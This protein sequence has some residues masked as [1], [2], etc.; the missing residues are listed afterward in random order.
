M[1]N[2]SDFVIENG[3]LKKY[4]G[5]GG[6]VIVPEGVTCIGN[7]AFVLCRVL[8]NITLPESVTSIGYSAF[9]GCSA[10]TSITIPEG[11]ISIGYEAFRGC[12][13]LKSITIPESV[14]NV[15]NSSF[16]FC[17]A[18]TGITIPEGV[19]SIGDDAFKN[20]SSLKSVIIPNS[21]TSIGYSAF[22]GCSALKSITLSNGVTSIGGYA[23]AQ[24][25]ALT[26]IF[27][28][29]SV[30]SIGWDAF[31][32][33]SSLR[34]ITIPEGVTS[35]GWD[36]FSGCSALKSITLP[37]SVT[38][39]GD[40]A[41]EGCNKLEKLTVSKKL[42]SL[43]KDPFGS[44]LPKGLVGE[45][46]SFLHALTDGSI[47][48]YIL[49]GRAKTKVWA[50]LPE[51]VK[52]DIFLSRQGKSLTAAYLDC[53][54]EDGVAPLGEALLDKL[55][56]ELS[57]KECNALLSYMT[58]FSAKAPDELLNRLFR[59]L[60]AQKN[61]KKAVEA[62]ESNAELTTLIQQAQAGSSDSES[63]SD[64]FAAMM[65]ANKASAKETEVRL[66]EYY[67][68]NPD[69]LPAIAASDAGTVP[70]AFVAWLITLHEEQR[71]PDWGGMPIVASA[72]PPGLRPEAAEALAMIDARS[73]QSGLLNLAD[74]FLDKY[75]NTKKRYLS[76]PI[77][78]YADEATMAE[79]TTRAPKWITSV[80]GIDA[81]PLGE[82]R[83]AVCYSNT[84]AAMLF[85]EK[86]N[87]LDRYA[88]ARGTDAD[89]IRDQMLSDVGLDAQGCKFYDLGNQIVTA[90]LQKDLSFLIELPDGK[91]SKSLPKKGADPVK[92]EAANSDFSEMKKLTKKIVRS[93]S[94]V[95]FDDFLSGRSRKSTDW[96]ES[97]LKNPLL[98]ETASL[99]VW[100]Q[101]KKTFTISDSG[102]V[103]S[104]GKAYTISDTGVKVAH[105]MDMKPSEVAAWQKYFAAHGLKQPFLQIWEPVID[106]RAVRED[107]YKGCMIPYYR[108]V[109]QEKHGITVQDFD[110][111]NDIAITL[112]DC[113]A[114][115][116][117]IDWG[118]HEID[119]SDRFEIQAFSIQKAT[120]QANHIVAY[121][122]RITVWDRVRKDDVSVR[123]W[124]DNFTL[125]QITE[126][127]AAAQESNAVNVL[128]LLLDYKNDH[129]ADYDPMDEFT[130]E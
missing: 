68:L 113:N 95:L 120:R 9:Y 126:F 103:D 45:M 42:K 121:L 81:P 24:C 83:S 13:A 23:F 41:F 90:R 123:M 73:L 86:Y 4:S 105:P 79:M 128:A 98:R 18:L 75:V 80:S 127:I 27:I 112:K 63:K 26:S 34:S 17:R 72:Y 61:G 101:G 53:I 130:L 50:K 115:V 110:F 91:T 118:R 36:A 84:R 64:P 100:A 47:K 109:H 7:E 107:R 77:C 19:K 108:F 31:S 66:K 2:P 57:S 58:M 122:D 102:P 43:G 94:R 12:S 44:T 97:Y 104:L 21:V 11:L 65:L 117:R 124:L 76:F 20:C 5:P 6:D 78:R 16:A 62:I 15:G 52:A 70:P 14:T 32:G 129:F 59:A 3:V 116:E 35:I 10:M 96:Q 49:A 39:I 54:G 1:S 93:R 82:F 37:E 22:Y 38:S 114:N 46:G 48:Q 69:D 51:T 33:C 67:G 106:L 111:H 85:A 55:K 92:Y 28:P 56:G 40:R 60:K 74:K 89:T 8:T 119:M 71:V 25:G 99:L 88:L 29:D 87:E 30:K 125:A